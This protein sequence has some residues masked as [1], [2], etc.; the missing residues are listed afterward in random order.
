MTYSTK[1]FQL[2][3][4]FEIEIMKDSEQDI[5]KNDIKTLSSTEIE[6]KKPTK[7]SFMEY[8]ISMPKCNELDIQRAKGK[9]REFEF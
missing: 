6:D 2:I 1:P 7:L 9:A 3:I 4:I 5:N 8:L